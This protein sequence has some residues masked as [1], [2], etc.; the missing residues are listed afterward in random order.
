MAGHKK[1]ASG[2]PSRAAS[3]NNSHGNYTPQN[4]IGQFK[5]AIFAAG[6]VPPDTIVPGNFHRFQGIGKNRGNKDAWCRLFFD[7]RGGVFGDHSTGLKEHWQI[8]RETPYTNKE[9]QAFL[10]RCEAEHRA[11]DEEQR[12]RHKAVAIQAAEILTKANGDPS[13]HPYAIKKGGSLGPLVKRGVWLQRGWPDA[14]IVSLY[15]ADGKLWT[16]EA[17]NVDGGKDFLRGGKKS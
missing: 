1:A 9:R 7:G 3:D 11:R 12:Q 14:L 10:K 5:A 17:I 4:P 15:D 6:L 16:L 13:Q 8:E 2:S